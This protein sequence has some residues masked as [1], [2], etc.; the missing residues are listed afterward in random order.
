M[1]RQPAKNSLSVL[2]EGIIQLT[3]TGYQTMESIAEFQAEIDDFTIRQHAQGKKAIILVDVSGVTGHDPE[4]RE[5]GR[6]RLL[7]NY[8]AMAV[9]GTNTSLKMIVNWLIRTMGYEDRARFFESRAE[10]LDWL[11]QHLNP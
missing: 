10:A 3:Q 6:R 2:P 9:C 11:K 8:D 7:G 4:V 1:E 5:E